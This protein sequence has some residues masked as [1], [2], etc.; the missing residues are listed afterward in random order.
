MAGCSRRI[1][2][3]K[4]SNARSS[5]SRLATTEL[6]A[7]ASAQTISGHRR[8]RRRQSAA[9][10]RVLSDAPALDSNGLRVLERLHV[11]QAG[12]AVCGGLSS[13]ASRRS[14]P[15]RRSRPLAIER[16]CASASPRPGAVQASQRRS[17]GLLAPTRRAPRRVEQAHAAEANIFSLLNFQS[18]QPISYAWDLLAR[19]ILPPARWLFCLA[20]RRRL[21]RPLQPR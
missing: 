1:A 15:G 18:T 4:S 17:A 20:Q 8:S 6:G 16:L 19:G 10:L 14:H 7:I 5:R 2:P 21:R 3:P 11:V 13:R 12:P 9:A